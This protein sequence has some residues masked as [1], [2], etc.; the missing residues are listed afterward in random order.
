MDYLMFWGAIVLAVGVIVSTVIFRYAT[1]RTVR[2]MTLI[3]AA[4]ISLPLLAAA[5]LV[6][7]GGGFEAASK[8]WA[9][10]ICGI[11]FGYWF[12]SPFRMLQ[13]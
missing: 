3:V 13:D 6:I 7:V 1:T 9:M 4:I 10:G 5:L 8:M 2:V 11:L 12:K